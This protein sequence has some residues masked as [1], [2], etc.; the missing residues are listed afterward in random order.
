MSNHQSMLKIGGQGKRPTKFR[1]K[2]SRSLI[3]ETDLQTQSGSFII[4]YWNGVWLDQNDITGPKID[5]WVTMV[6]RKG[7]RKMFSR[8]TRVRVHVIDYYVM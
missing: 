5:A 7:I 8:T 1:V 6:H 2:R 3:S 4:M